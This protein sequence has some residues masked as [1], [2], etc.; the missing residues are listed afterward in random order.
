[1]QGSRALLDYLRGLRS[2]PHFVLYIGTEALSRSNYSHDPIPMI[3]N[4][5][6]RCIALFLPLSLA[7]GIF[8]SVGHAQAQSPNQ[9][10]A[11]ILF[12][13]GGPGTG[14][15]LEGGSDDQ[16]SSINDYSTANGNHGWGWLADTLS[17]VGYSLS[18]IREEPVTNGVPT[19]IDFAGMNLDPYAAIVLASNNAAYDGDAVDAIETYVRNGGGVL[20]IS[21]AN[22][23]QDWPDAPDSDQHFLDRF[24]LIMNQDRGTYVIDESEFVEASHPILHGVSG[25]DGEGVSPITVS[26]SPP[27]DVSITIL[28]QAEGQVRRNDSSSGP[29]SS[30]PATAQD[31]ALVAVEA[32]NG[33][34]VGHFDRNTF[35]NENGAGTDITRFDNAQ[36]AKNLFAWL[37]QGG[38]I[39]V[40]LN[41]FEVKSEESKAFISWETISETNNAGFEVQRR[42]GVTETSPWQTLGFVEGA[43]T[44]SKPQVYRFEDTDL[45][46]EDRKLNYRLK[47]IDIDGRIQFSET[48]ELVPEL[49]EQFVVHPPF[50]NPAR[51]QATL[52]YEISQATDVEIGLYNALGQLVVTLVR[53]FTE[54]GRKQ[55]TIDTSGLIS[56]VYFIR[57]TAGPSSRVRKL[58]VIN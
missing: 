41:N 6:F 33:H 7:A 53:G 47:Q 19:P 35:F 13:R 36:Y 15:F 56:G 22:F 4:S 44:T 20:F 1:M 28:A 3:M 57:L 34:I 18:E 51:K 12:I 21:D 11:S 39:P 31:A 42:I 37:T 8:L 30:S 14:G 10:D 25:F 16:L 55:I 48:I 17:A 45:P 5:S 46:Y 49:P 40:E 9:N 52:Q 26:N 32:G 58:T 54:M 43:G 23:G 27:P 50:P 38:A 29:G 24:G 2:L